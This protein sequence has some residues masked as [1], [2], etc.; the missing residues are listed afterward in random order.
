MHMFV[1]CVKHIL[2]ELY[3]IL[4]VYQFYINLGD[5]HVHQRL[6]V[7]YRRP[8]MTGKICLLPD[9]VIKKLKI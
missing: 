6:H 8:L 5:L 9:Y 1:F 4:F 7:L 3:N 2:Y